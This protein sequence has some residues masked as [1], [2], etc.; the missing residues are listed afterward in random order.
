MV[1]VKA[2]VWSTGDGPTY[3]EALAAGGKVGE[4]S[5]CS[6]ACP[7]GT[8]PSQIVVRWESFCVRRGGSI[9]AITVD[10]PGHYHGSDEQMGAFSVDAPASCAWSAVSPNNWI[11][12]PLGN[13]GTGSRT[14]YYLVGSNE[15][16]TERA[17]NIWVGA[18]D[19]LAYDDDNADWAGRLPGAGDGVAVR[20]SPM[21]H[22]YFLQF[23][24][25][26]I[27]NL[28]AVPSEPTQRL[29][30]RVYG[31]SNGAPGD[32]LADGIE[33]ASDPIPEHDS[34]WVYADVSQLGIVLKEGGF[35]VEAVWL[36]VGSPAIGVDTSPPNEGRTWVHENGSWELLA[37]RY[38]E[39]ATWQAMIR[40]S[41]TT[42]APPAGFTIVQAPQLRL[43]TPVVASPG[44]V[45]FSVAGPPET[46][47]VIEASNDLVQWTAI[48]TNILTNGRIE[49]RE[50]IGAGSARR[51][52]R[53]AMPES[54]QGKQREDRGL[55][56]RMPSPAHA[57]RNRVPLILSGLAE[58][59]G[60]APFTRRP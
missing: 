19:G 38:P 24:S 41:G 42:N 36:V 5:T 51:F 26:K 59:E 7:S 21:V 35:F 40:A 54:V 31:E 13:S 48:S 3:E 50:T 52:Y 6:I 4:S 33:V 1:F 45:Q 44:S 30:L 47:V 10:P 2:R 14:L 55:D 12:F 28:P 27:A 34:A 25:V 18:F 15:S 37:S 46:R 16:M 43:G 56:Y 49:C 8:F 58:G 11:S 9:C 22:P 60:P 17:G 53:A 57:G 39:Y 29:L 32:L 23:V 20:F